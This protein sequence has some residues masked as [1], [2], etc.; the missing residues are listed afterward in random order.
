[1]ERQFANIR[2]LDWQ[3]GVGATEITLAARKAAKRPKDR[4]YFVYTLD[5]TAGPGAIPTQV[6]EG[7]SPSWSLN[8]QELLFTAESG[9]LQII[10][11]P[12]GPIRTVS[13]SNGTQGDWRR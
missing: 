1:M 3:G 8:N 2:E 4:K 10:T 6:I 12:S 9:K 5:T 7:R 13:S 11:L